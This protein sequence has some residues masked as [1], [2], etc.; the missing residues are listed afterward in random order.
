MWQWFKQALARYDAWCQRMGLTPEQK[1]SC[2]V[3]RTDPLHH[4]ECD[5]ASESRS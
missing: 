4:T 1:R 5:D 2:V 3:Y